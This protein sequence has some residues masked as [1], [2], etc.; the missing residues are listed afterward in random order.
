M[1]VV[2]KCH[3]QLIAQRHELRL[4]LHISL[5][6]LPELGQEHS[7]A[8]GAGDGLISQSTRTSSTRTGAVL[9]VVSPTTRF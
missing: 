3:A 1:T 5:Q 4:R 6:I 2:G 8:D 7:L 9:L